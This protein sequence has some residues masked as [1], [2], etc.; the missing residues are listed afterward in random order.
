MF[1]LVPTEY[2]SSHDGQLEFSVPS[3][4]LSKK[5]G[6]SSGLRSLC[7]HVIY[8]P[9]GVQPR[10][11]TLHWRLILN[12]LIG[13]GNLADL[14][15]AMASIASQLVLHPSLSQAL[16]LESTALGRDKVRTQFLLD[17][18]V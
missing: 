6:C 12:L 1:A 14:Y 5:T 2:S 18:L 17:R 9:A 3:T 15:S 7:N 16:K 11:P 4:F 8:A 10:L 13:S